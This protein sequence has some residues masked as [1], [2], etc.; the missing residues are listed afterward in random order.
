MTLAEFLK[1]KNQSWLAARL[2]VSQ[3]A[4]SQWVNGEVP[5]IRVR[6][7]VRETDGA[8]TAHELRPDL[9]PMGFEFPP[10]MLKKDRV[11]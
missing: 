7:L 10:E 3:S 8:V 5:D 4:V 9:Y 1:T 2:G 6:Q 11:A